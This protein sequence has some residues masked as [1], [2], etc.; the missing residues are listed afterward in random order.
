MGVAFA[1]TASG[2]GGGVCI[3]WHVLKFELDGNGGW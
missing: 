3:S 2:G 1:A